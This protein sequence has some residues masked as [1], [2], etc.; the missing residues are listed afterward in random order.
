MKSF[1]KKQFIAEMERIKNEVFDCDKTCMFPQCSVK[2]IDSHVFQKRT[3]LLP[4]TR[5]NHLYMFHYPSPFDCDK[6]YRVHYKWKGYKEAFVF[7]GFCNQHDNDFFRPIE[8]DGYSVN[9]Y[10]EDAQYRL[11]YRTLCREL[12]VNQCIF[13]ID[14]FAC[15][16]VECN[17][18]TYFINL[19]FAL[20]NLASAHKNL[21]YYKQF[22]ENGIINKDYS[23]FRFKVFVLPLKLGLCVAATI[24]GTDCSP[25]FKHNFQEVNI[26]DVFPYEERTYI[27][28]GSHVEFRNNWLTSISQLFEKA[29]TLDNIFDKSDLYNIAITDI[30]LRSEFHCISPDLYDSLEPE[31]LT[32]FLNTWTK[33][34]DRFCFDIKE[35]SKLLTETFRILLT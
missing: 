8:A 2:A 33:L 21:I 15:D 24:A 22:F 12:Y 11:A 5:Q 27:L 17:D 32:E 26:V 30:L 20:N 7:K 6:E 9:W 16:N 23:K 31:I 4:M 25:C 3:I 18:P 1:E 29:E 13:A 34:K 35:R 10:D 28:L 19:Q 14:K